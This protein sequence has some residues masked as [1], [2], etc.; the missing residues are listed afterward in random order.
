MK[1]DEFIAS[2]SLLENLINSHDPV[3]REQ[4]LHDIQILTRSQ[5]LYV[6]GGGGLYTDDICA[7]GNNYCVNEK[8]YKHTVYNT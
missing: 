2:E 7:S 5:S 1:V 4:G 6:R 8:K 3:F